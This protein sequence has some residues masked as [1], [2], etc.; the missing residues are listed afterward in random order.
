MLITIFAHPNSKKPRVEKDLFS[1]KGGSASGGNNLHIY[2]SE[3]PLEGRANM[4]VLLALAK[5]LKVKRSQVH[6][7]KG[8]KSK[9]K[10]FD[11][12]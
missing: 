5:Y 11:V 3:P 7:V 10:V 8:E 12:N 6:L 1:A 9:Q 4:A 2:I